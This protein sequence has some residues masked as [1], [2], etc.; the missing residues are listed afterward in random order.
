M[1]A[2]YILHKNDLPAGLSFGP[3]LALDSEFMG[4]NPWRDRL[5]LLQIYDGAPDGKVHMV[6]FTGSYDAPNLRKLLAD[7]SKEKIFY[8]ARGD[9]RWIGHYLDVI[10]EN[11]YCLKIASRIA[12]TYT[13]AHDL[14]D[15]SRH[16]LGIKI[17]KEQQC[18]DWGN[19]DLTP[20]QL[21]YACADVLHLHAMREKL[22]GMLAREGR[23][24]LV[25]GL[26]ACL[27]AL[28]RTDLA[29]W[30]NEDIFSYHI[31]KPT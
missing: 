31:P 14:E 9:M 15:V 11:V 20:Q 27:P 19:P 1:T 17:S 12:R 29:G 25:K 16:V 23:L 5:C 13:Q 3:I 30:I 4:L 22:N 18:T 10:L 6:Q 21:D 28:V 2:R 7:R 24:E 26:F 8:F